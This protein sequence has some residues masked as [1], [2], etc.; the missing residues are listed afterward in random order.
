VNPASS[1]L[2]QIEFGVV[3]CVANQSGI[4]DLGSAGRFG[5]GLCNKHIDMAQ[6]MDFIFIA[7]FELYGVDL[8]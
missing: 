7:S 2:Y 4:L 6:Q 3:R 1:P 5:F 8:R